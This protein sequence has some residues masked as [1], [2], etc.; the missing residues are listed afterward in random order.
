MPP[1][2]IPPAIEHAVFL[3]DDGALEL[4]GHH[5]AGAHVR[6]QHAGKSG[7]VTC[8]PEGDDLCRVPAEPG[9][10]WTLDMAG[11]PAPVSIERTELAMLARPDAVIDTFSLSGTVPL[12]HADL[13]ASV[14]CAPASCVLDGDGLLVSN[15]PAGTASLAV[16]MRLAPHVVLRRGDTTE[17][18]PVIRIPIVRCPLAVVS[19][20]PLRGIDAQTVVVQVGGRCSRELSRLRFQVG[21]APVE[22]RD[23]GEGYVALRIHRTDADE[24]ALAALSDAGDSVIAQVRTATRAAPPVHV[25]LE[26]AHRSID[27]IPTNVAA[28][29]TVTSSDWDGML[30]L[31]PIEGVYAVEHGAVRG[32]PSAGGIVALRV[33][34]RRK[35]PTGDLDIAT[36]SEPLQRP[37]H[38]ATSFAPLFGDH[39][40]V[41]L[42]CDA[43]GGPHRLEPGATAHVPFD[44][45]DSCRLVLHRERLD[46]ALGAQHLM[47]EVDVTRVDGSPRSEAR[48]ARRLRLTH[49][50][51]ARTLFLRGAESRF[52]RY[53]VRLS[54]DDDER[55]H[56]DDLP[57]AQWSIITGRGR[58][59]IYATSAIP[60]GLYRV[61]DR[62]HSGILT[63][64]FGVLA[65]ATWLDSLGHEGI[66]CAEAGALTV[67][68]ANDT[69]STG[70]SLTQIA[71]VAGLGLSVPIANRSLAAETSVNLHAWVELEP[72]RALGSGAGNAWAFVF[73]P[74]I[75]VGNLG[76]DL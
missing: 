14:D 15:I 53:T 6:W 16:H 40:L 55:T 24:V 18:S 29:A 67:G 68:L 33:V 49:D 21:G 10:V 26:L 32:L 66:L 13:I 3:A 73:G 4:H 31:A 71:T 44:H 28:A 5:L 47:L 56:E 22:R 9:A 51:A 57:S 7:D 72:S 64:N 74:S 2:T 65:R 12:R 70:K 63:L 62:D 19:G 52:D 38:E 34:L 20:S 39:P 69:S 54:Q 75:T 25:A 43:G 1:A 8:D 45:H 27:F 58:A 42:L 30:Q 48:I 61:S 23:L 46:P 50:D 60:T 41:E 35:L 11:Y 36:I 37:L 59:R 76:A 17:S